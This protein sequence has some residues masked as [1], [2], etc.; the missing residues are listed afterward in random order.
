M[1]KR[2]YSERIYSCLDPGSTWQSWN[3][4]PKG[5]TTD[6]KVKR[7]AIMT[8]D[9][10][11]GYARFE[12]IIPEG[13]YGAG[14]VVVWDIGHYRNMTEKDGQKISMAEALE[15]GHIA[16]FAEGQ[17]ELEGPLLLA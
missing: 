10:P 14:T 15:K 4:V 7:L 13:Q 17:K 12:G 9:H 3:I 16:Y 2:R 5:P 6:P 1:V 8:E 11:L